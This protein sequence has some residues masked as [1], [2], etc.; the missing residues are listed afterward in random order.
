MIW[1]K[2]ENS[3][4]KK[5]PEVLWPT[6]S[7]TASLQSGDSVVIVG[8]GIAGSSMARYL[9]ML[10]KLQQKELHIYLIN[11]TNCNYCGGLV[12]NIALDTLTTHYNLK[13]DP[14]LILS[15]IGECVYVNPE[16]SINVKVNT[17]LISTLR[18][19]KFGLMGFDD[20]IKENITLEME[21]MAHLLTIIE[22]TIV[23]DITAITETRATEFGDRDLK[24][25]VTLSRKENGEN[26]RIKSNTLVLANGLRGLTKPLLDNFSK[27][28][29]YQPP[30]LMEASVTEIDTTHARFNKLRKKIFI[31]DGI[32]DDCIIALVCKGKHWVTVTS[33]NK[34]LTFND[35]DQIFAHPQLKKHIDLPNPTIHLRCGIICGAKVFINGARN[36]YGDNWVAIGDL[37]GHGRVLK[38]G[39]FAALVAAKYA[40]ETM[41]CHGTSSQDFKRHYYQPLKKQT[42]SGN[43]IGMLLFWLNLKLVRY[44]WFNKMMFKAGVEE[45]NKHKSGGAVHTGIRALT[46][47]ELN[48]FLISLLF[49]AGLT[50]HL[51][52]WPFK[53]L[54][55]KKE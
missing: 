27:I 19:S 52:T 54:F 23:K 47:G 2:L 24:W 31:L 10:S 29:N 18:T 9:L 22:P 43:S 3:W 7:S 39:Y 48:Y 45:Q 25:E 21:D 28:T 51:F 33:L 17:P 55:A 20:A 40:A 1:Q 38:D 42:A 13:V 46:T 30:G 49:M 37:T 14:S 36:F 53:K 6:Q 44:K 26:I 34:R 15:H 41:I 50:T 11:S 32:I 35:I 16:G 12:T 8:G 5:P 4:A